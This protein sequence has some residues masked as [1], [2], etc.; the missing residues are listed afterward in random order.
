MLSVASTLATCSAQSNSKNSFYDLHE[1]KIVK[2]V[3]FV[4][5]VF[6]LFRLLQNELI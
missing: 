5:K 4:K 6:H 3:F 2:T 1:H